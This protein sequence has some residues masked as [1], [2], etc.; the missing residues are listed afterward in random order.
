MTPT[1]NTSTPPNPPDTGQAPVAVVTG[2]SR[3]LGLALT[4][5]LVARGWRVVADARDGDR[6]GA[7]L[8][9]L[10]AVIPPPLTAPPVVALA[11]DVSDPLHRSRIAAAVDRL[12]RLD[13]LVNNASVLV[14]NASLSGPSPLRPL[15]EHPVDALTEVYAVNTVAPIALWQLLLPALRR[16]RGI[17]VQVSSDAATQAYPGWGGYGSSKAALDLLTAVMAAEN[18]D[19]AVYAVDPGDMA[20]DLHQQAF[21]G[22]DVS[23]RPPPESVVPALLDLIDRRP[24]SGRYLASDLLRLVGADR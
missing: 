6:L 15:A 10:P 20:T 12:G 24:S 19:L 3:G 2:A 1:D 17:V 21:P 8:T 4:T 18:P 7:A 23:D 22:E 11:G 16:T 14:G 9:N 13:L 5:A